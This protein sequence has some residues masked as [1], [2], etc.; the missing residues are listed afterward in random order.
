MNQHHTSSSL[1]SSGGRVV[2][3]FA[4]FSSFTALTFSHALI[5]N[6]D[7]ILYVGRMAI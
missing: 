2:D 3:H 1:I 7:W 6:A 5:A 4:S